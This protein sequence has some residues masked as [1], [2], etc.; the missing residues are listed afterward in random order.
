MVFGCI[1]VNITC[2]HLLSSLEF[3]SFSYLFD[4][5]N[6]LREILSVN[7]RYEASV[8]YTIVGIV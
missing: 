7:V 1:Y 6:F 5:L 4:K 3:I 2:M 8:I